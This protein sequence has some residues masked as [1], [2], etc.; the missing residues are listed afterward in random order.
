MPTSSA[1]CA[2]CCRGRARRAAGHAPG[3]ARAGR[4]R[5]RLSRAR[6]PRAPDARRR[7]APLSPRRADAPPERPV[8]GAAAGDEGRVR[9]RAGS[10]RRHRPA[11]RAGGALMEVAPGR[12][13][14]LEYTVRLATGDTIDSTGGCGPLSIL[15]G[16]G[17]L[18]AP[19]E[20]RLPWNG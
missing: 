2:G 4:R 16:A 5:D 17:Q 20:T 15:Y 8:R 12:V 14:T 10:P 7:V 11:A 13:V 18:F 19:V 1:R 3:R 9:R 6:R